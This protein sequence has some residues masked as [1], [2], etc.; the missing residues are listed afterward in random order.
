MHAYTHAYT[1]VCTHCTYTGFSSRRLNVEVV[2]VVAVGSVQDHLLTAGIQDVVVG[3]DPDQLVLRLRQEV[4]V[5][6][7]VVA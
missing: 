4:I 7:A 3:P 6:D 2:L 1:H 5:N